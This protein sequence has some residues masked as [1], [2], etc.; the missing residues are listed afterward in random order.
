MADQEIWALVPVKRLSLAK[1]RLKSVLSPGERY[2]L[3]RAMLCDVLETLRATPSLAGIVVVSADPD[4]HAMARSF[5]ASLIFDASESGIND[6]VRRGLDA[7]ATNGHGALVVPADIPFATV[8]DFEAVIA[9]LQRHQLVVSPALSDGGTNALAMRSADLIKPHFGQ[10]SF[11]AHCAIAGQTR[12]SFGVS[13]SNGIGRDIDVAADLRSRDFVGADLSS[14][15]ASLLRE[16]ERDD[17]RCA[18]HDVP[19]AE[20]I[21]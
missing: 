5:G 8:D 21:F 14:L 7:L 20:R 4:V 12:L 15:T 10:D 1:Q 9:L 18:S 16:F 17:D 6:A 11:S 19:V 13:R 3:A 2:R